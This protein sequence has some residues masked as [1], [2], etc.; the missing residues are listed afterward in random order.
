M[1]KKIIIADDNKTYLMYAGLLLKRFGFQVVPAENGIE[2]LKLVRL[3]GPDL[4]MLDVH[5]DP[6]DGISL[7]RHIKQDKMISYI[8]VIM[9]STDAST[10][11]I[12]KCRQLGCFDY[13]L[14][15]LKIDRVHDS[16]QRCFFGH[17]GTNRKHVRTYFNNKVMVE[18]NGQ[19]YELF[20]ETLSEGGIYLRKEEPFPEGTNVTITLNLRNTNTLTVKG[21][22]IYKKSL[23][24]DFM[25]FPPG[26]AIQFKDL[27]EPEIQSLKLH[28]E[29]L[30][31]ADIIESGG[32]GIFQENH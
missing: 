24:G 25:T 9:A 4:I 22:V 17:I 8:P 6:M 26:M 30:I 23:F 15:P 31:A 12:Q 2:V 29:N 10:E 21:E 32:T 11:T 7:L 3:T 18:C 13:L 1:A 28:V 27:S 16:L 19:T 14:K 5:M 20:S